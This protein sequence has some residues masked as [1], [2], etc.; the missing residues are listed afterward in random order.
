MCPF[1][2]IKQPNVSLYQITNFTDGKLRNE[3]AGP[4]G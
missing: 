3:D 4:D 2:R 1:S